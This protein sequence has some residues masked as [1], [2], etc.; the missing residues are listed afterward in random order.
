MVIKQAAKV[1][2]NCTFAV[3]YLTKEKDGKTK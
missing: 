2:K 3:S 1:L